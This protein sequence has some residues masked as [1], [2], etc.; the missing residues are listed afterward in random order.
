[1]REVSRR[2]WRALS[3]P[4]IVVAVGATFPAPICDE[5]FQVPAASFVTGEPADGG[6]VEIR[7]SGAE[8]VI[9][10]A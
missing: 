8:G 3:G 7:C 4:G 10:S 9:R 2:T 5:R 1:M 6:E